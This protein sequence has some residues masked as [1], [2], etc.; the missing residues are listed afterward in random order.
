MVFGDFVSST[1]CCAPSFSTVHTHRTTTVH[2]KLPI[3]SVYRTRCVWSLRKQH[4]EILYVQLYVH[5]LYIIYMFA[6]YITSYFSALVVFGDFVSAQFKFD[7]FPAFSTQPGM[8]MCMY[9]FFVNNFLK[10]IWKPVVK[11][12]VGGLLMKQCYQVTLYTFASQKP[13]IYFFVK[14]TLY[15]YL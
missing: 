9:S 5:Q 4:T 13:L 12:W 6:N 7:N 14:N 2:Q 8:C 10:Y 1:K 11:D 3:I 15:V